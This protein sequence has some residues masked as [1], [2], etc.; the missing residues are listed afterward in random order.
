MRTAKPSQ[1]KFF[2]DQGQQFGSV[3]EVL[4]QLDTGDKIVSRGYLGLRHGKKVAIADYTSSTLPATL[5]D[6]KKP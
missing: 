4:S 3:T 6:S 2:F 1:K 5:P